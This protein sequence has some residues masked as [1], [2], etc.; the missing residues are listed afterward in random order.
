MGEEKRW[1]DVLSF[2][3]GLPW[4][5]GK[6]HDGD[7]EV[8]LDETLQEPSSDPEVPPLPMVTEEP[9]R[10]VR[11]FYVY[12]KDVDPA[13]KGFGFVPDCDGCKAIVNGKRSVSHSVACRLKV[14]EQAPNNS[15]IAARVKKTLKKEIENH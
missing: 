14:L 4:K 15:N 7:A 6:A 5:L 3:V 1:E 2:V 8:F 13:L 10:K 9:V 12:P 11:S